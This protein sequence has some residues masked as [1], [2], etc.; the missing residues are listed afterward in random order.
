MGPVGTARHSWKKLARS[1]GYIETETRPKDISE[2]KLI[3]ESKIP[4]GRPNI[5]GRGCKMDAL[6]TGV[7][8]GPLR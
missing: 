2:M 6:A 7:S 5:V 8:N 3:I 4:F 1:H